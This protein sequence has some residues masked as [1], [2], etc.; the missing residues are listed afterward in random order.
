MAHLWC[1]IGTMEKQTPERLNLRLPPEVKAGLQTYA[2]NLGI[3]LNAAAIL[4]IRNF[5][6]FALKQAQAFEQAVQQVT[7]PKPRVTKAQKVMPHRAAEAVLPR[8]VGRNEMCPCMSGKK[9][10]HCHP[11]WT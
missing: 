6:P 9:A 8:R 11:E 2:D 10:K 4:A 3:S 5:L 1:H 7:P